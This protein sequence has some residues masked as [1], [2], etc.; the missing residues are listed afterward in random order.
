MLE[1]LDE[2]F[3]QK[4]GKASFFAQWRWGITQLHSLSFSRPRHKKFSTGA[5]S[6]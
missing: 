6:M 3:I 1:S 5:V 2:C 4:S